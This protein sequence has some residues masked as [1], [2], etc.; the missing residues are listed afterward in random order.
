MGIWGQPASLA[1]AALPP[2]YTAAFFTDRLERMGPLA[3]AGHHR[4]VHRDRDRRPRSGCP[5]YVRTGPHGKTRSRSGGC[6][7]SRG[8]PPSITGAEDTVLPVHERVGPRRWRSWVSGPFVAIRWCLRRAGCG[9]KL[10]GGVVV[11]AIVGVARFRPVGTASQHRWVS[12]TEPMGQP[13]GSHLTRG[14]ARGR[15]GRRRATTRTFSS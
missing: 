14:R 12:E 9:L 10:V 2:P 15:R 1:E 3:A 11:V 5:N 6:L 7:R 4:A 13:G 8:P